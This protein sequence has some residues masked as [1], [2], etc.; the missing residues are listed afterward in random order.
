MNYTVDVVP[1][2]GAYKAAATRLFLQE[3]RIVLPARASAV[4][5]FRCSRKL[6]VS[7]LAASSRSCLN[8]TCVN[9]TI[10]RSSGSAAVPG[11]AGQCPGCEDFSDMV[12]KDVARRWKMTAAVARG[13]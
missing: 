6:G 11:Q 5:T 1:T 4:D 13:A 8:K 3:Y 2:L 12:T 7:G 10:H 9:V